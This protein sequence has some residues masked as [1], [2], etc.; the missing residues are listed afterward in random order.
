[1]QQSLQPH[2]QLSKAWYLTERL[3]RAVL[4]VKLGTDRAWPADPPPAPD[5]VPY[6]V[7][8]LHDIEAPPTAVH[9]QPPAGLD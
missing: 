3:L 4:Q 6:D 8:E 9:E 2:H 1:M 7:V 5:G